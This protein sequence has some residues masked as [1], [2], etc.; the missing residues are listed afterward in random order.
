MTQL[1]QRVQARI[2]GDVLVPKQ[3][4]DYLCISERTVVRLLKKGKLPGTKVGNQ[5]RT[6]RAELDKFLSTT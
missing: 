6:K 1:S 5:W 4:A 2:N 3:T